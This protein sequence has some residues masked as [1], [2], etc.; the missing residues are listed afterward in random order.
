MADSVTQ[1]WRPGRPAPSSTSPS[2][3]TASRRRPDRL[4]QQGPG[5]P[6]RRRVRPRLLLRGQVGL[7]H[8]PGQPDLGAVRG[9]P[10]R[11]RRA[12]HADR[13]V[14]RHD[15]RRRR[16]ATPRSATSTAARGRIAGSRAAPT[17]ATKVQNALNT[18]V[19][20]YDLVVIILNEPGC[21][22]CGG[23]GFQIVTLGVELDRH[24]ARVRPRHRRA[25]R[26]VLREPGTYTGGEPGASE[27]HDQHE[28]RDA[29]VEAVRQPGDAGPDR[30][31]L[32]APAT[33]PGAKPAGWSDSDDVGLFEGGGTWSTR[34]LP[35]GRSTAGCAATR[36]RTARSATRG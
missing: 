12:R 8:L 10:A 34:H 26:R 14:R 22:G 16:S 13:P 7:Q 20:D 1:I 3:A 19:P 25:R 5:A 15:H 28:P 27:P 23:G 2:S 9:Q 4:Q 31:R 35:P 29:Q 24:G 18:W 32:A 21:G 17:P 30:H 11:L 36:R 6:A 33:T